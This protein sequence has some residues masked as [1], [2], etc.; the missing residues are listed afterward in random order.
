MGRLGAS[1]AIRLEE[2]GVVVQR[3]RRGDPLPTG[4]DVWWITASDAAVP[5]IA[6]RL[7]GEAVVLH[8][9][10]AHGPELVGERRERGV[11]HPLMTFPGPERGIPELRGVGARIDGTPLAASMARR[12]ASSLGMRPFVLSGDPT[13]YHAA[14]CLASGH[15]GALFLDAVAVLVDA[16]V[17]AEEAPELLRPLAEATLRRVSEGGPA[18]LTGPAV[19]GDAATEARHL[20]VLSPERG[21]VYRVLAD[22]IR[23]QRKG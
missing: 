11:L 1:V 13:R 22:R 3:W 10:G 9:A 2:A 15:L 8:A 21:E 23:A 5:P 7:P 16:G 14:A 6:A 17:P 18:A 4:A 19:R 12:I 20:A